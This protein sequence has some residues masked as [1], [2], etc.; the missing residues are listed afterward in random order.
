[1]EN[2]VDNEEMFNAADFITFRRW[3]YYYAGLNTT[4]GISSYPRG[5][6]PNIDNDRTYFNATADPSAWA[7]IAK[8]WATG[9]WDGSKVATTDWRGM[10][11]QQAFTTDNLMSVSV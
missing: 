2:L 5:D 4:T 9:T 8:G 3:A 7:N 11:T 6:Q 1:F 10:V